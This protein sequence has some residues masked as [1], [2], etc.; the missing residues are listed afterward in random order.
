[1]KSA[2]FA[3]VKF[4]NSRL[5]DVNLQ[6]SNLC[7][8]Q[9]INTYLIMTSNLDEANLVGSDLSKE[10]EVGEFSIDGRIHSM[11]PS[12]QGAYYNSKAIINNSHQYHFLKSNFS[13]CVEEFDQLFPPTKFPP[14]FDPEA[15][16]MIDISKW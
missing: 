6:G 11:S 3:F 16:G 2:D 7:F 5:G 14:G 9:F 4:I 8:A 13:S 12:L 10:L 1:M 15:H